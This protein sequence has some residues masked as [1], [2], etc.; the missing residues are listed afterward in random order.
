[1]LAMTECNDPECGQNSCNCTHASCPCWPIAPRCGKNVSVDGPFKLC[2]KQSRFFYRHN[3]SICG[4]CEEHNYQCGE[5]M[6]YGRGGFLPQEEH[7]RLLIQSLI[8]GDK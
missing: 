1:M 6:E 2:N 5:P 3:D 4:Y 7:R 8:E